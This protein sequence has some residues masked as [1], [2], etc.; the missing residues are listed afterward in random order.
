MKSKELVS[1]FLTGTLMICPTMPLAA[2]KKKQDSAA[3]ETVAKPQSEREKRKAEERLKKELMTPYRKWLNEDVIYIITDEEK[4]AF[5]RLAT[6]EEREQF[7]EQFWLR[8]DPTPDTQENEYKEEH[9]RRIAYANERYASGIPGWKTDRGQI[10]ITFGPPDEIE[11]HPSGGTYER[12][13]EEGGGTTSTY[14][15][16]KWRYRYLANVGSGTDINIEFVDKT[17]TGEY[18]MTMDPSEKDALLMVP[19][20]GLTMME[21]MGLASKD[22]R[23]N[24]TDGTRLGTG[25]Q[26]LP[27]RMNQ[28]E[29][30]Q[31]FADLQKAPKVKFTD[32]EAQ[33]NS[34]IMFNLLP[35][36]ARADFFPTT[37][38]TVM[39]NITLQFNRKDLQFKQDGAVSKGVVNIYARITSMARRVVNVFEDVVSID[40]P[41]EML[42]E[43]SKGSS[44]YQ[45]SVPLPPGQYR[46]NVVAKDVVGGNMNNY[47]MSLLVPRMEDDKLFASSLVLADVLEK[48]PTRNIGMGQFVIGSSKVRP[49]MGDNFKGNE[50]MGIYVKLYN[51]Q[52]DEKTNKPEGTVEYEIVKTSD[53]SKVLEFT[54]D[55][56]G[57]EGSAS[58]M[59]IEKM[60]PLDNLKLAPGQYTLR[61]KVTDKLRNQSLTQSAQ[62][63][64]T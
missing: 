21:Q 27:A 47:E 4:K 46:L 7:I 11:S 31:Q 37:S 34:R 23:F 15:F 50:K 25:N 3:R 29:R 24:R 60:L 1:V 39:T 9:Y 62:F 12:P 56:A 28:F 38:S 5:S 6:D 44:I 8:R 32:L 59:T 22:D 53:N 42:Q 63:S 51:F 43:A 16:E 14:P 33:V 48:V 36:Q 61:L 35:M 49:R 54:E 19:G 57:I 45:K 13:Y 52:A 20:A 64:I 30:L 10:Y 2:Q 41:T 40:L 55:V 58:Q 17:M 26:P 18:R